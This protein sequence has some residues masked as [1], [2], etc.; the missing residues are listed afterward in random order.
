MKVLNLPSCVLSPLHGFEANNVADSLIQDSCKKISIYEEEPYYYKLCITSLK[1]NPESQKVRNIDDLTMVGWKNAM[2][3][4]TNVKGIVEKILKERKNKSRLSEK[5]LRECVKL[6]SK[7]NDSLTK[8]FK[9]IKLR[10]YKIA[11]RNF[12]DARYVSRTCEM[13]FNGDNN[14]TSP[15]T[16]ENDLLFEMVDIPESLNFLHI[17]PPDV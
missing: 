8:A 15:V 16:K 4:M 13:Q 1:E 3:N 17:R 6:Y 11:H 5:L 7:G 14:Q 10:D 9:Y 12:S 2:T